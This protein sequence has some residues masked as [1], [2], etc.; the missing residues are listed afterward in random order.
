M[1]FST[2]SRYSF[3][4]E[5]YYIHQIIPMTERNC[6][7]FSWNQNVG[8]KISLR[9]KSM[10][11][12]LLTFSFYLIFRIFHWLDD[13]ALLC[14]DM[15]QFLYIVYRKVITATNVIT[16]ARLRLKQCVDW[17]RQRPKWNVNT[18]QRDEIS[19]AIQSWLC[20][21]VELMAW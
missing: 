9:Q 17:R 8:R 1:L 7:L 11:P 19:V 10:E 4:E 6:R 2:L 3:M 15:L 13:S 21:R 14:Y 12:L 5:N 16:C 20:E 18:G